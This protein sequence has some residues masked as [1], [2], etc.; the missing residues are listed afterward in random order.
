MTKL[1]TPLKFTTITTLKHDP[2][3][4]PVYLREAFAQ[5]DKRVLDH[6]IETLIAADLDVEIVIKPKQDDKRPARIVIN[7]TYTSNLAANED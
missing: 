2:T 5:Q 7:G 3:I 1:V 4:A 6:T